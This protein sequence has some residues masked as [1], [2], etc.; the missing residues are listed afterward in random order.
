MTRS[1]SIRT[2]VVPTSC[3]SET[4]SDDRPPADKASNLHTLAAAWARKYIVSVTSEYDDAQIK[5]VD[6][7]SDYASSE[8]RQYTTEKLMQ[9]LKLASAQAWSMTENLLAVEVLRHGIDPDLLDPWQI[10]ADSHQLFEK[11]LLAYGDQLTAQRLS[12]VIGDDCGRLRQKYTAEDP[13]T[14]GFVSMQFHH[15]G[16]ILLDQLSPAEHVLFSPYLKV[17]DD[18][19][20]MPLREAYQ[21]AANH[22]CN[23][24]ELLA[25]QNLLPLSSRIAQRVCDQTRRLNPGYQTYSGSLNSSDVR[26][27]SLRDIEMFQVYLCLCALEGNVSSVQHQLFPLCVM[28]YPRLK[29]KWQMVQDMLQVI[30]WEL[31]G[32]LSPADMTVLI[33]YLRTLSEMFSVDVFQER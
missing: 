12:V 10:A 6:R 33:P 31:Y 5:K 3:T 9:G 1:A 13:R 15:T 16:K 7:L 4:S 11:A 28:L 2:Q 25:V 20:Y 19:M 21:A 23:S 29:V 30:G 17:M 26:T 24:P 18:H 32:Q 14:I 22:D 27:S 8:G